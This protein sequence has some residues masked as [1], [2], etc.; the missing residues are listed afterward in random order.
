MVLAIIDEA[1]A[2]DY[3]SGV[4]GVRGHRRRAA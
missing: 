2:K 1:R 3:G 4:I